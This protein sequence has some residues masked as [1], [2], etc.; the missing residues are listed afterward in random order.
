MFN[1]A[2]CGKATLEQDHSLLDRKIQ[3]PD[4]IFGT[5]AMRAQCSWPSSAVRCSLHQNA[6]E[7]HG[8]HASMRHP[9][10]QNSIFQSSWR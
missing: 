5:L 1:L 6:Q 4:S 3:G 2:T 8:V 7:A 10:L 9:L